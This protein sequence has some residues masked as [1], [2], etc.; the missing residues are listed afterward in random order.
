ME[1]TPAKR[2][3]ITLEQPAKGIYTILG[4]EATS[5]QTALESVTLW[6][7]SPNNR[8]SDPTRDNGIRYIFQPKELNELPDQAELIAPY[9]LYAD[10]PDCAHAVIYVVETGPLAELD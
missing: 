4:I 8:Q 5:R 1:E 6:I 10:K 3:T 9:I 7:D 2:F